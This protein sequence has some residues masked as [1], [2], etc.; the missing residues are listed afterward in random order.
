MKTQLRN[1]L[2]IFLMLISAM[3]FSQVP[4]ISGGSGAASGTGGQNNKGGNAT[5]LGC[6]G[7]GAN[8]W[9]GDGGNGLYGGG[10]G[11]ASGYGSTWTGGNGG[12]GVIVLTYYNGGSFVKSQMLSSG[13]SATVGA[14]VD[15]VKAWAI[16][17]GGGGG[18]ST[19]ADGVSGGAGGAGGT[20]WYTT[21]VTPGQTISYSLGSAGVGGVGASNGGSGGNTSI[22]I[23]GTTLYGNGGGGGGYNNDVNGAGGSYSGGTNGATGGIG[24][25]AAGD[26]GGGGGGGI[27]SVPGG[28][29]SASIGGTGANAGDVSGLFAACAAAN[30]T[31]S[32]VIS[33]FTPT[34]GNS[35]ETIV[36]LGSGYEE[37]SSVKFGDVEADSFFVDS[38]N[39]ITAVL[40]SG[41][42]GS[43]TVTNEYGS[44]TLAGFT[45]LGPVIPTITNF[46][47]TNAGNGISV[48]ITG[49]N[50][51]AP[52]SVTFGGTEATSFTVNSSTEISAVVGSGTSGSVEVTTAGGTGSL[53]GFTWVDTP[54]VSAFNPTTGTT[55]TSVVITGEHFDGASNVTFG[56]ISATSFT[57]NNSNQIT[58]SVAS[59]ASGEV[60][61]ITAGGTGSLAGFTWYGPPLVSS[62]TPSFGVEGTE[63]TITGANF[64]GITDV[65]FGGTAATSFTVDNLTQITATV[66]SGASGEVS[67]SNSYGTGSLAGFTWY[68]TPTISMFSPTSAGNGAAVTIT[69]TYF[70]GAT[71][72][73]FGGTAA[74]SFTI[75]SDTEIDAVVGAG[76]SGSVE[77]TTPGGIATLAGFTSLDPPAIASFTPSDGSAGT[78]VVI[79]GNNFSGVTAVDFGGITADSFIIDSPTQITATVGNGTSGYIHI[80]GPGGTAT[81]A[82]Q[83]TY[84]PISIYVS[85]VYHSSY[86][87]LKLAFDAINAGTVT[88]DLTLKLGSTLTE[89]ASAVLNASGT[90]SSSYTRVH[91]YPTVSGLSITG[92]LSGVPVIDFSGA[93]NVCI[94]GRVN[95]TG[96]DVDLTIENTYVASYSSAIRFINDASQ[97]TVQYCTVKGA[98]QYYLGCGV[99]FFSTTTGTTGNDNNVI[100]HNQFTNAGGNRPGSVIFSGGTSTKENS[101]NQIIDNQFYDVMPANYSAYTV[102]LYTYSTGWAISGNSFYETTTLSPT[103]SYSHYPIYINTGTDYMVTGNYIGGSAAQCGGTALTKTASYGNEFRGIYMNTT[104]GTNEVQGNT[105]QNISWANSSSPSWYGIFVQG[106]GNYNMGTTLGNM[107]GDSIGNG[108]ISF[109]NG[110]NGGNFYGYYLYGTGDVDFQNNVVGAITLDNSNSTAGT[111]FY[112]IHNH[113]SGSK[114]IV[115]NLVGS[116]DVTTVNS[117]QSNSEATTSQ[118]YMRGIYNQSNTNLYVEGNRVYGFY[119]AGTNQNYTYGL[120][121]TNSY[122]SQVVKRNFIGGLSVASGSST[123]TVYGISNSASIAD[124]C[125]NNIISI[126]FDASATVYGIYDNGS[127]MYYNTVSLGGTVSSGDTKKSYAIYRGSSYASEYKDNIFSNT[128]STAGGT[129]LHYGMYLGNGSGLTVDY[130]DYYVSGEGGMLG[131][132][133]SNISILPIITGQDQY[134]QTLDP[135]YTDPSGGTPEDYTPA[136]TG[137]VG[138]AISGITTDYLGETRLDPPAMGAIEVPVSRIYYLDAYVDGIYHSGYPNFEEA[139]DSI[140]A[141][142]I[143]GDISLRIND[144]IVETGTAVLN[145]S[146]TG[147]AD[148]TR[149]HIYPTVSGLS[150]RSNLT[151]PMI[152]LSGA[153]NVC[154]DGRVNATG[155]A[156]D[157]LLENISTG[158]T[159][160]VIRFVNDATQDTLQYCMIK[161]ASTNYSSNGVIFFSGTTG[162]TGNDDNVIAHNKLTNSEGNRPGSVIFSNGTSTKENSGNQITDNE[163]YDVIGGSYYSYAVNLSSYTTGWIISDN[164]I[165]ETTAIT[166]TGVSYH[167]IIISAGTGYTVTGN[168]IGGS[169]VL[170][171]GSAMSK[172][173]GNNAAFNGIVMTTTAGTSELQGNVIQNIS[174]TNPSSVYWYGISAGGAGSYNI[175][176]AT[177][178]KV[179]DS[180]GTASITL[181]NGTSGAYVCGYNLGNTGTLNFQNNIVG[182]VTT[183]SSDPTCAF[184]ILG[185]SIT[186]SGVKTIRNN[187]V[188]S[189]TTPNSLYASSIASSNEQYVIGMS[190]SA[191][192]DTISNNTIANLTN[193]TTNVTT[194]T[195]GRIQGIYVSSGG[196][197][198]TGNSIHDL[199]IANANNATDNNAPLAG[200]VLYTSANYTITG[201]EIYNLGNSYSSFAGN[202]YGLYLYASNNINNKLEQNFIHDLSVTGA[203]STTANIYGVYATGSTA[204]TYANNIISLGGTSKTT[205]YGIYHNTTA[206]HNLYFNTIYLGDTMASGAANFSYCYY[207]LTTTA[208]R[209]M[210]DNMFYNGRST[211]GGSLKH[212]AVYFAGTTGTLTGDYNNY[213][214]PGI[215]GI[216]GYYG[217]NRT[218]LPVVTSQDAGSFNEDPVFAD[219]EGDASG[220]TPTNNV[221]TG[222]SISGITTDYFSNTREVVPTI[223]AIETDF[224]E[225]NID[226]FLAGSGTKVATYPTFKKAFDAINNGI[227]TGEVTLKVN[228]T[229]TETASAVLNASGTGSSSYTRVHIYPTVSGLGIT[230]NLSG[231]PVID[232]SGADNVCIDGRVNATGTDVDLTIENT[233]VASYSSAIRF[234]NDASQDTVQYCTVKGASQ[235][236]LGCGVIFFSTTTGTTGNDNNVI[237]HNQFTNAGGNRPGSVIFS[238]GTSTKENSGNQI[239]DNQF[240]DVMPANYSAYTVNLYTY[241]T[242]WA[243]SGN[244][245]YETTTLSP[246]SSYSHYPIY[247]NTGTDYMVTGN[248]IGGSAA[249]CG[250][251]ALTKTASYGNEFRGIYMNTTAGT[252]EVQGN[253]I[254]NISWANS[255]SPSWYGI[256]VQGAGNY[257]MGTTLGNMVGDSIGNGSISFTN[258]SNGGNFY[259][260]YLHGTGDVDFQNNVVG[261]ITLD[262]SNS[263]A[264]TN[265]YGIH[266][267]NSGS[268]TIVNNLV[269]SADVTTVNSIQSNSEATT[270]QQYMRGIYNQ[271]NTNLYVEGNRVYGFYNAGTNQNYTYGLYNTNSY[272]SQV[273]KRNFI[274]GLSV[275]SG[276]STATVYGISNSASIADSCVNNIISIDFDASATVYGIYD[277]GSKMYYNTVSLG[278]TVS[279]GDTKKSYAIYRGSSYASEYKD[280]I[281]SNTR[282]TAGG[283]NLHYGMYLGNG[284]GLTVDYNDYYVSG[285]GGMLG[286][287]GSNISILPIITGQD[288]YSQTLDPEYT[289]PSGGT[290]EDYTP[291][292]TGIVGAAISGITTDYLGETRLDPPAMGAI[293]VPVSRIYYLDA[294]VDGIYHS[295]YPNFE[296][297][298]DSINAGYIT[299]DISLRINDTIVETGTAVLNAS[300]TGSADYTRVHI[301]PTVSGLSIRS[302]LTTPM[303]DL[304]G[305]DN[306]CIDGR[307]NA[308]GSAIDLLLENI[309]TGNTASVIR[310]VND[311]TQDTLQYCMIK[312]A[313]TNY[314]S[315]GVIFFSGTTGTT[316][317]DDNVI[318]HNK[319]TNSEGNRPGSV[320]FSNGTSTK[321]NS[322]NQIT[323]NEI[324]DVIGGS[325]YSYAVNLSSYTTGWIISDNSIYET[326]AITS[327][328]VSYHAIIISAGTGYTV[329]G[330]YIGGSEVLCGGS[331]MSK[332]SGNNAAFNGIVMT[333]TAGTSELQGNVIQN[334]SWTNPSSVYWY[335]ISAGGAGSY[336]IGTATGNKVGDSTGTAS[337]TLTNGTSGAYVCGYNL[338]NTGTLNFQNNIVGA[339][340]TVSSDPTCAFNILGISITGSGVKTI[341]NNVVGS[342]TTPNSLYASSIASSN[343]QYVIGMSSSASG[344]TISNNTIANLTNATTNVTTTTRGRIQGIYV[345]SG[346][347]IITGNSIHDLTIANANNA[348]D[349]NAPL[350]GI[351]L[352]TS[353]NYTITGNEIYNLGNSYSSFAGNVYGLYLYASNNINNKLEQN[354]IHDLSVTGASS[355][356]ANI[357]GVYATGS[358]ATTYANNIISLGGTSKTTLY[359]IYHNTT[360]SHNLYFNT[361]YLGDTM[362]SGAANFSYCYYG[363]TTTATR[364]MRDNMFYNGRSTVGGSL[365]HYAVYFA[366]TTGTLTG[367][368]N[369]YYAPG[370]GGILGYYGGNRT[371]LPVVTSQDAGSFNE[372]P[373]FAD[374]EGDASGYTPTN[375]VFTGVSISGITT[376]YFSNTRE[377]VPTIGAIETDFS[378]G[379]IDAFLAGSGT[380]VATYPTFKKAFDAIN[381]G[382]LTGEVTLKVNDTVTETASAV[383][384]ASGTG[385]SSYTRV[386][387]YPT[388]SGLGITGN[389][390]GVPVIDLSGADNVC[391]DGRVNATGTDVDLTIENTY[392]ASYSS[393]I[394]FIND[395]SQDT[396]QYCTVKGASQ[397][398]LGCGVIFFSTTTGTTGNDN[399]VIAHNQFTNAGGNRPGSV[400]FSGGTSTKEN[401]GNQIIDNQFYDVMPANYSAYTVNLYTYSTGWAISGNSFYET[402]TLSPTSSY[403]HY[404]IYINTGTDYMVT[405]NYI[406]GSAAQCGGTALTKTA[407]YGNEFRGIYMNTTAGTNEVQGNTIQNISWAN[408]SSPSWYG[409]FVQG[410]GNYNMGT[411]LGNMVG[412]SIGN[413]SISFTN[414][415][416]G[417][418]FYGY[419]LYGTG[420]VDFQNNVV[421]AITLDNSNSTA[422]TNF[423][424]IHNHNSGSKT[425]VN[426]LVGSA[427]VTTVNSIQSNS[428]ATTSQQYMR[429]I[430]NQ[431]NTNL[432]VEGNRVYGFYNAGTNQNYTYGLYNTNSYTSQVVKRNFIGGLSVASGSSTATVYGISNSASIADSCVNNIISIDFDASATVY[433]I[434]DNGSKMYYNTVS[435]G[436][437]VSSGD[438]KKSYAIYRGSSYASEYKDNIFSNTRST[439]GGTNLHYGMYLGNG[440]GLTVDYNDYYVSG[441]GGMLGYNGS[442][443]SILPIITGQDQ[444]SQTLDPEYTDPSGGTAAD[445]TPAAT[446]I[447][448]TAI[449]GITT[450]YLGETRLDPPAMGAIE[451]PVSRIYYL[452]AYVDGIYHSGYPNFEEAFDSINAGY[453]TGDIS[454]R[455]ND[456]I[457]ET[458]TAV[459]NASGTGSADYTRVHIYP[460]VSGLS[461][462]S[463]LTTPMI[464]LSGAD[465][466]CIDGRVNAT[467]SAIDLLLE[468]ISTG[469]TASVIRFVNDATQDTL[470]YCM[471]KGASTNYSSNGVIFFS[472]TTG[473]TGNDDNVIAHNKLTNSEG[474]RPGSVIFSNGTSTK[475]NSGNQITDNEIYDVIGGSYYSYAVNLS[476]YTTGWIISDNSIYETTAITSTGVSYHAIIISAGTGYTVTGNYIGGS[477]VL[478]GGS[479]MSKTSGNNAAFNGIVMTTTAGTSELQGNVIQ[480]ISWTNPSSVYWYGIS[481]GGAGSY[482]IGTATGNKVGDSTGTASITL[483]NGTSGA[484]VCGYN[485][486]NTGTLNFQNNIVGAVTTVSSDP[487][488]AFNILG[489]S[490]T[491]SGVKTIRNNVVGSETTPNSLYA[492]SIASSNEQ[493]VIG[494]SSSASGDTISNNTIANLTNATTNVTTTTRGRIQGIYVSSGGKII[495]GNSIH[496]LTIA[497]ANNATDNNA[498]LAG[499]VLYTSANY[500][501]TGNEIYNLGNSYSSFAGNVYGLYLYASNNIN[502][503]LEQNFIHDLSVTG[504]SSTTANIYGVYATG[505]TAT[506]YANNIISLG[507][508]SKTTL[509]G[510]YHNTTASHNLYFNTIYLGDT[511]ASGA[512]NFSYCYYGLTTTATRDMR[513]NMFYNGRSTVGGSLKH[514]AVYFA[515]TTGTLTGD[516]NN[517]YAPG[518]GGI[519]GYYGGNRTTLPV[520]TSQDAGSFNEDPVFA[521]IE[522]DASGYTPTNNVFTGVSISGITTDYF[523]NTREVVPTIG[524]IE[525]DFSEGNIDAFL[526]GSGTK[527]ATYPTFKKAFDAIN[528]GILTGE[529]TLKV[530]DTV[531]ETASAVLN[532]SGTGSS[533]YTRVHIY[534]TVSGLGITGNLS[535]VPVIDLSGADN[536][537]IDGRVNATGTDVDLTI[538]NTYVASY[539]SAIR[540]I[541][542]ASQDTVQY[543]TVKGASQYYLGCGVI[544]FSTTTGTTGNDNNVIAHN[545]FT[546]AGGNRPGSVIFSGGTSTKENSGNQII[547]N[548]FYDVMPANYSAYTVNLYTYST[549]WAISGNSFY[550]TTTLSPTSSYSHYPIYINTGTDYMVT[551][552]YIGG[553]A[554]QCGGTALTKTASYGNE[555]RGIYMN[556]TA[557]TNEVQGNTIQNISWANSSSPSWY[558]IF[559]QG[560]GN[561]NMGT[562]LGNMVGDSIGNG[563]ISFTNGS[564]GGNFYGY[565][566]HGTGDVDFQN[567]VVGAITLD[568]SNSTAGTNF[569]GIHNHNSGSKTIVNNL[570]GSADVTTVNSIQSNSEATTSQQYMRG[571]YNQSNTNLY[572]EGNRVYGF[573]NAGTNQ[574]YTYG[575]YNTNSYTSQVV[576]RNFIG[577]LSVASGSS[578]ATVYGISN[579]ASIADSCVNNIISIDFDASATVY[580]IYDNGSKMYYNTVS[581]GGT[582]SS[583]DTKKSY[584]IYRG[585]SYASEY[586]DNIFSNTRSTAGGTNLHYGM[587]LGNGSGLTVDYNDYYVSG[588]GGMLGYNGSNIS[589]LPII[590]GQDQYSQTLDPEY[591]DPSGGTAADYMPNVLLQGT[592]ISSVMSDYFGN[593]REIPTIGALEQTMPTVTTDEVTE[594]TTATATSGGNVTSNAGLTVTERGICW[595]TN[596]SPT[597]SDS[598]TT[599]GS[600]LGT[601]VSY[602]SGLSMDSTYYVRAYATCVLGTVYGNEVSFTT[603]N[604]FGW[605]GNISTDWNTAGNWSTG[606]VPDASVNVLI[607]VVSNQPIVNN[608]VLSPAECNDLGLETDATLE[609]NAGKALTI[610][611][612]LTNDGTIT[613]DGD[614][615]GTASLITQGDI[616]NNSTISINRSITDGVWHYISIPTTSAQASVFMADYLATWDEPTATWTYIIE[617]S[618]P[619]TPVQGYSYWGVTKATVQTFTGT[620]N[621]GDQSMEITL[622][623]N[624]SGFEGANLLGNPYPSS[625]DWSLLDDTY[626]AVYCWNGTQYAN[627]ID[628]SGTN[629]GTQYVAPMQ[630][631]FVMAAANGTFNLHNSERT[632]IGASGFFKN[633]TTVNNGLTVRAF[634]DMYSDELI[635]RFEDR[636]VAEFKI[637]EDAHKLFSGTVGMPEIFS[638]SGDDSQLVHKPLSIDVRPAVDQLQLGFRSDVSDIYSIGIGTE[639]AYV[640]IYLEDTKTGNFF[641][642]NSGVYQFKW[643]EGDSETRFILHFAYPV[644]LQ[645]NTGHQYSVFASGQTIYARSLDGNPD[646]KIHV[647]DISGHRVLSQKVNT[648]DLIAI[649]TNLPFGLYIVSITDDATGFVT[650]VIVDNRK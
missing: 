251:T 318:A 316:G 575:L 446:G 490:I 594:I 204:T 504:A 208:T 384:N 95:A 600:G 366:G 144:T 494:M 200:I 216:L 302:N 583:G 578:T 423:Y 252:N 565:Y 140:N 467:G 135:E 325:Y 61:V 312:G 293:E 10:G 232:L 492:S 98:S 631:F 425:I 360:A 206:S 80:T 647:T 514:Y 440:S 555:F 333:T 644:G 294:Y 460:T 254:Q 58:A 511:M 529:V 73:S 338:G 558:G 321:E 506:T 116:A 584:A 550:E 350:A 304:S 186:G 426:N 16:G 466:V 340:T 484:Y 527:V 458:G 68:N 20:A 534:P 624:A 220:Y 240:Y 336:N 320:I 226:A 643:E 120:Y 238:G 433:G 566:L 637:S 63:I 537:C 323:D 189:E 328:G 86:N 284:S 309:S 402:T 114:T 628:G 436:G 386:H 55:G 623:Q 390:S 35:G 242:G 156:I 599:E 262:N 354:F 246:T 609:I 441:E 541:N 138:A 28:S 286:Y 595:S 166:S 297:A 159:A 406:G 419:Y 503:K 274:G 128:R 411:T 614:E 5:G 598:I 100:A 483:T 82:S 581:L 75:N 438:T 223:G 611:G 233:Y 509:Y 478:C 472:G 374:I 489:I 646:Y 21:S 136:A 591:T 183:V 50:F 137:I 187:V 188:G 313:S 96:T 249:Q 306:V 481:A 401:S 332:T 225:G 185:I 547:D 247:I 122:T 531:T 52:T 179:G 577:G 363:L 45:F 452:D 516:Y 364:D 78:I 518:I 579:S 459:L 36:I 510:I 532:A 385:S 593:V 201:N 451:V 256:F 15:S 182:A 549:G 546:N 552:N 66:G 317:N 526:A 389:L 563:S 70:S 77:V 214:A 409:I 562:T 163:I 576:K 352:Y 129:N 445:Y 502:N 38:Y 639:V 76:S 222:V 197:I 592:M 91:I 298:F 632:H 281:F 434:Y 275:A 218:T 205:L 398:Y 215:G 348:T 278:G 269:G 416:N 131:Y 123:A 473:T 191:S 12:Q 573:Y 7:G 365:K 469:N 111:N 346:G 261:A 277:N 536:V 544:F 149:V 421:G 606:I 429:G 589:I 87:T 237:A 65:S 290:P 444:Y 105:I 4:V 43:I 300:G 319:L 267:H 190:S 461:I 407:S 470:Q 379:N 257:N 455:I 439:A 602:L 169:E 2:G 493:Y 533:S 422:G 99:I 3:A 331:A 443:I 597:I 512:A 357:Y 513:D 362:A 202:V 412:D 106:A 523:S 192:G 468:N 414:G 89:T 198:I 154:I 93:D 571:I 85:G 505:S 130:N 62:F 570:V 497:N 355:T 525:T 626:G 53:V 486:G 8:Y 165:Y 133:G 381:N 330:N 9:G 457:V 471:I 108:S 139:F 71:A 361:I 588:E 234:I 175:G 334:I 49:T 432:Y 259:G 299:G 143:T 263:T 633:E 236:Y 23:A 305:A 394:R 235:Y 203:S 244:S 34:S 314:S 13:S 420:D 39:Q 11:G 560:A 485:L 561:Y 380:K 375:N 474:N 46:A 33:S 359:G 113:N 104:A 329:T 454:L 610:H 18:G 273:V 291:A 556:T 210:R 59:G 590:T 371:T 528:N 315:N 442:N 629:G 253:T 499:I 268:K 195:R 239:I 482:N 449:S 476:S 548:Q 382:I 349:N 649:P 168:Y 405:G 634:S 94:D 231:V 400:I 376:D 642:L 164:S 83:F 450:D 372:D 311:A 596:V 30:S 162:T 448:G 650:K 324:Y 119:N 27:G 553:S 146:G 134:S 79:T 508:T 88:G 101:G 417:G 636:A 115:N 515:G 388:V 370:I 90:G 266:N 396:V 54:V 557:G 395:A 67:V 250:G 612:T 393:A 620:P 351:V 173:S 530:N 585:S 648:S 568:N 582:V 124:S 276:S 126:D 161:G 430:Y 604:Y 153:D 155:S 258:G 403:S 520:V 288:Q 241:S 496:D 369:N 141:G 17:G 580:G 56:E 193:A 74:A 221:F 6:G 491:G 280:N 14:N 51:I 427:D 230:G 194:T 462:R 60:S 488:C 435:L 228:D 207:G 103:S 57:V 170:C 196:K 107:V 465:N 410:A 543:C 464:D 344:D 551:G 212:Y 42:S 391:I 287:N 428:E 517:Y 229:V 289:D 353:A 356:T 358:T 292:A 524:A 377:V 110:S 150:I 456:T 219:I 84:Y 608:D 621:T 645:E 538:E 307:V 567:N 404:P 339:V 408:S 282:S 25:G 127:K 265:F 343:E 64:S 335:G 397:Y 248:Y 640:Y 545:Q 272:T 37:V 180:T 498:P 270:S 437:T 617:P 616:V 69:G 477:E 337:I 243:I 118:Q 463:N 310:F 157:L 301:Y 619:L 227:L 413:G 26:Q 145:A 586:K 607:P 224:S 622:T 1:Y 572:V 92:N 160:S 341:R 618:T 24:D 40:A 132:N 625:I 174:W 399:N 147:S 32:P 176:T 521:D 418:N 117:I 41:A 501:I 152:D 627:W 217:G 378:E 368:Y 125:V 209:D 542:D 327:T 453:I 539:S 342:E 48:T 495:T 479:A 554:A 522:G 475:E 347:K 47:P 158:N 29:Q 519:L 540:F 171:G 308:T 613:L 630:G 345:S 295:G 387:I 211:V 605:T 296:E 569:Y 72:V 415:S 431:S 81:S 19:A 322:G 172:T 151:T 487:T 383:L 564:N 574:N 424:G 447:V 255:S 102:N 480:N 22:T 392:V 213:Y 635:V 638:F 535:G 178:N 264:G 559:V 184:N 641:N 199:T 603:L 177:G 303:I 601:F 285:E 31:A 260:Y 615:T 148:Y 112:G 181:T 367:D 587:Y 279:S 121:N 109:T 167:A 507:G 245:F 500:T 44:G 97:D 326:T 142:Y 283:T 271:S 373:V